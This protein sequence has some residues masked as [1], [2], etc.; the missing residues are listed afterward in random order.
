M[1]RSRTLVAIAATLTLA[2]PAGAAASSLGA[3]AVPSQPAPVHA[4]AVP[5][6]AYATTAATTANAAAMRTAVLCLVNRQ[7]AAHG[8]PSLAHDS[9]LDRSAQGWTQ[10]MVAQR[11]FTH[12][13]NFAARIS[14]AGFAWSAAGENIATGFATPAAVV[15]AWM[16]STGH[17]RNILAPNFSAIGIG[18]VAHPVAG[19][20]SGPATWTQDFGLPR[21]HRAPSSNWAAANR[22]PY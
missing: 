7:R 9:R 4:S 10:S 13:T 1:P 19:Y 15:K 20:A 18:V 17:C 11:K 14:A 16:A 12:G 8:L 2:L 6:C 3:A 22:C 5:A 21:G